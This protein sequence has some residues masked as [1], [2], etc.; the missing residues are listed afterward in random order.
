[1][2]ALLLASLLLPAASFADSLTCSLSSN[3]SSD[4]VTVDLNASGD[5]STD[6]AALNDLGFEFYEIAKTKTT[7][8]ASVIFYSST[9]Q[10]EAGTFDFSFRRGGVAAVE[11]AREPLEDA[12]DGEDYLFTCVYTP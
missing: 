2:K 4:S 8:D 6:G 1:M 5:H 3:G 10:D 11:V 7:V 9:L 12:P